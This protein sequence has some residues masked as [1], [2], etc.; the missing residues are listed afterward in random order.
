MA[1]NVNKQI[2]VPEEYIRKAEHFWEDPQNIMRLLD[3]LFLY[4][5]DSDKK[6][7]CS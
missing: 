5:E 4:D 1:E 2:Q 7:V 6:Q 3:L